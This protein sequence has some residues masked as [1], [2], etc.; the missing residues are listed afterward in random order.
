MDDI[1][2]SDAVSLAD[3]NAEIPNSTLPF[4]K[5]NEPKNLKGFTGKRSI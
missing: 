4:S 5:M 3:G 2:I 1:T